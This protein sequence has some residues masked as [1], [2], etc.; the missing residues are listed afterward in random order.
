MGKYRTI[1]VYEDYFEQFLD[2][3]PQ[4]IQAK[5]LQILRVIEEVDVIPETYL[6]HIEGTNGLYEIRVSF[7]RNQLRIFCCFD[8]GK[9]IVLLSGFQKKKQK[10]PAKEIQKAI[11]YMNNYFDSKE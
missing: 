2:T 10:T 3:Q 11:Q 1:I 9:V 5:I 7:G 4:K 6:K 8:E